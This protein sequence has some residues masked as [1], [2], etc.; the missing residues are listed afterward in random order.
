MNRSRNLRQVFG[1]H[2][3]PTTWLGRPAVR[4]AGDNPREGAK[5]VENGPTVLRRFL[6]LA[7]PTVRP[8]DV[9]EFI[10]GEGIIEI[11]GR[12]PVGLDWP[13]G[14]LPARKRCPEDLI[15][16][17]EYHRLAKF[18][19]GIVRLAEAL[20]AFDSGNVSERS[21]WAVF[22]RDKDVPEALKSLDV[23]G[24]WKDA[25]TEAARLR[26]GRLRRMPTGRDR[27]CL[28]EALALQSA[29]RLCFSTA[30]VKLRPRF[31]WLGSELWGLDH[32]I[33]D[34]WDAICFALVHRITNLLGSRIC[35]RCGV[36]YQPPRKQGRPRALCQECFTPGESRRLSARLSYRR[37]T[38]P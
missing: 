25:Q 36:S 24:I 8:T 5:W 10:R 32:S 37:R 15:L 35:R 19:D 30:D 2:P 16:V 1:N 18:V 23:V 31:D 7:R 26:R 33:G 3:T 29:V 12:F 38:K 14:P 34:T 4:L 28:P 20:H 27:S 11:R 6:R 17:G 21:N 9:C 22:S 13:F